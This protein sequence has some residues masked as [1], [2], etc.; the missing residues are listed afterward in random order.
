MSLSVK[1]PV[2]PVV[3]SVVDAREEFLR[4]YVLPALKAGALCDGS[5]SMTRDLAQGY[6]G[7]APGH[8]AV[9]SAQA[10]AL[11]AGLR[12]PGGLPD[13]PAHI[14]IAFECGTPVAI[15]GVNMPFTD[16][17]GSL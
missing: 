16:L 9:D 7:E 6:F 14:E 4:D 1:N 11:F 13:E 8:C 2:E 10:D 17:I 3:L 12:S 15:N 5:H